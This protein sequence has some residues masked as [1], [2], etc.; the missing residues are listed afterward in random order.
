MNV[1]RRSF[2]LGALAAP[3]VITTPGL[4]MPVRTPPPPSTTTLTVSGLERGTV[5]RVFNGDKTELYEV[6]ESR[7]TEVTVELIDPDSSVFVQRVDFGRKYEEKT[8]YEPF[9]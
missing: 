1:Q 5:I 3:L 6:Q 2:L 8:Y 7:G 4:L 9:S